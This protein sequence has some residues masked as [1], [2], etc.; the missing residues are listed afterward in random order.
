MS[1]VTRSHIV[2][3]SLAIFSMLFGAGNLMYPI[4]VGMI[5]GQHNLIGFLGFLITAVFLPL[6][7]LVGMILFD[8]D[9]NAFFGRLGSRAGKIMIGLC[10]II[11]GPLIALPRIVS[12]AQVMIEPF[13]PFAILKGTDPFS[14]LV[15]SL[16]FLSL[17]FLCAFKENSIMDILGYVIS[18][19]LLISL[20]TIIIKGFIGATAPIVVAENPWNLFKLNLIRGYGTLDLLGTI[21][22]ASIVVNILKNKMP[23]S[24]PINVLALFGLKAGFIGVGLLG[25]VY[26]GQSFLGA[27]YGAGLEIFNDGQAFRTIVFT[28]VGSYGAAIV[29]IAVLMAC[30]STSIALSAVVGDYFQKSICNNKIGYVTA[31]TVI[32]SASVPLS[33]YGLD[34]VLALTGGPITYIGYPI[35]ISVTFCN[36]A[37][38]LVGFKPI[39]MPVAFVGL[40]AL[41]SY[42]I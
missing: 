30:F 25:L 14:L 21:F 37:Y 31:L 27:Y 22:F 32:L 11:L 35:L 2:S 26:F 36:I 38:K 40:V 28:I 12:V 4:K 5:S 34:A 15:F 42:Y 9:Y 33:I 7:G 16:I 23:K 3:T 39:K 29:A 13:L 8:G 19:L 17:T 20:T 18:P 10:M 24:T 41:I 6:T 1:N